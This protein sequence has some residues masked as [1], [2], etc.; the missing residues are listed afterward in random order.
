MKI[1]CSSLVIFLFTNTLYSQ[2]WTLLTPLRL[3]SDIRGCSFL[4]EMN[5]Y[6]VATVEGE[7]LKT[8]D[9]GMTWRRLWL[10]ATSGSFYDVEAVSPDT[11]FICGSNGLLYRSIDGGN[12]FIDINPPTTEW[13]YNMEFISQEIGFAFGFN[14]TILRTDNGGNSWTIIPSGTTSRLWDMDFANDSVGYVCGWANTIL[15]TTDA[16]ITWSSTAPEGDVSFQGIH[17]VDEQTGYVCGGDNTILKTTDGGESWQ[18]QTTSGTQA[19]NYICFRSAQV[20]WAVGNWGAYYST[21]NG[22]NTWTSTVLGSGSHLYCGAYISESSAFIMGNAKMYK[23]TDNGSSLTMIKNGVP[24]SKYNAMYF[25]D[26]NTGTIGGSVGIT[27]EGSNQSGIIHTTDGGQTWDVQLSGNSG[28]WWGIHFPTESTGYVIGG[29]SIAKTINSGEDWYTINNLE[30]TGKSVWFLDEETGFAGGDGLFSGICKTTNGGNDFTCTDNTAAGDFYFVN[31]TLGYAVFEGSSATVFRTINAGETWEYLDSGFNNKNCVYFINENEGWIGANGQVIHTTDGGETWTSPGG[32]FG[33]YAIIG[34]HFY[35]TELGFCVSQ[36]GQ[37]YKSTDGGDT[38]E[39]IVNDFINMPLV[40]NA[41]FTPNYV[42]L[43]CMQGDVYRAEL[44]CGEFQAGNILGPVEWCE[45][46]GNTVIVETVPGA[47]YDWTLPEGWS[48]L[49]NGAGV[50]LVSGENPGMLSVAITN[51]CGITSSS[52]LYMNVIPGLLQP[53]SITGSPTLCTEGNFVY[54]IPEDDNAE[55]Y[56]WEWSSQ[57]EADEQ[58]NELIITSATGNGYITV[59]TE[60]ECGV[61]EEI[62]MM[63]TVVITELPGDFNSD[64]SVDIN[65]MNFIMSL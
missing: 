46:E 6:A 38:W 25:W 8:S 65:D 33:G 5:G 11:I 28:G 35:T 23:S 17:F 63:L 3:S 12:S 32:M 26:D 47:T 24:R 4:D 29:G 20:G 54:S 13:L 16:G 40:Q 44:G 39:L 48:G 53:T 41:W 21:T 61:T 36:H 30:L 15:K 1:L 18:T 57:I 62:L 52:S 19:L 60:N 49:E 10:G 55:E 64:C 2:E 56:H 22:G 58:G 9:G 27:G 59:Y 51:A 34:V 45:N 37:L 42:Y 31:D 14:G 50:Q 7:I 43:G